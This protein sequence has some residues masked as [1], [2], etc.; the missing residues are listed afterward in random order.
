MN[1]ILTEDVIEPLKNCVIDDTTNIDYHNLTITNDIPESWTNAIG[2]MKH[3]VIYYNEPGCF[4]GQPQTYGFLEVY[5]GEYSGVYMVW[6]T[7]TWSLP[8]KYRIGSQSGWWNGH[9]TSNEFADTIDQYNIDKYLT[10]TKIYPLSGSVISTNATIPDKTKIID[11]P[12][13]TA[14]NSILKGASGVLHCK[15]VGEQHNFGNDSPTFQGVVRYGLKKKNSQ[16]EFYII[17]EKNGSSHFIP[18]GQQFTHDVELLIPKTE[19]N[20]YTTNLYIVAHARYRGIYNISM[21]PSSLYFEPMD[22]PEADPFG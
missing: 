8:T 10:K 16:G 5:T 3:V 12:T 6:Y 13:G 7:Q 4:A 21:C 11:I 15:V 2:H 17:N 18:D 1:N 14:Q 9:T 19:T 22:I 20:N